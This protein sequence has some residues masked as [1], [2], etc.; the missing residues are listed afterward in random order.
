M[1][2]RKVAIFWGGKCVMGGRAN[3]NPKLLAI[4]LPY[5]G[6]SVTVLGSLK[7]FSKILTYYLTAVPGLQSQRKNICLFS[8]PVVP[9][10]KL[11]KGS[12]PNFECFLVSLVEH[13]KFWDESF[14]L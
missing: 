2:I 13:N 6:K 7:E 3:K 8:I 1:Y 5:P 10:H 12:F 9:P 11:Q 4:G 14:A